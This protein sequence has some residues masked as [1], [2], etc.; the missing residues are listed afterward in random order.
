MSKPR[1]SLLRPNVLLGELDPQPADTTEIAAL[2]RQ[3]GSFVTKAIVRGEVGAAAVVLGDY[4]A[5]N[6]S[7]A[8]ILIACAGFGGLAAAVLSYLDA[9]NSAALA[10]DLE[11]GNQPIGHLTPPQNQQPFHDML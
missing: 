10:H 1:L 11:V 4:A 5:Y 7:P 3:A 8:S 6:F 2:R 9:A